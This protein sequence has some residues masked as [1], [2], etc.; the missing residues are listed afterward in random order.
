VVPLAFSV[1][2]SSESASFGLSRL[3]RQLGG[4]WYCL[5]G[6][7]GIELLDWLEEVS[8]VFHL[9][10]QGGGEEDSVREKIILGKFCP[11]F[12]DSVFPVF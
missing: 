4:F 3:A 9:I 8:F 10:Y 11:K 2:M 7:I 12:R 5:I 6:W 1:V